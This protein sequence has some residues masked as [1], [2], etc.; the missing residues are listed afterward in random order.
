MDGDVVIRATDF[1]RTT[2][3]IDPATG[4]GLGDAVTGT[5]AGELPDSLAEIAVTEYCAPLIRLLTVHVPEI[6]VLLGAAKQF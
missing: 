5:L 4:S 6:L 1:L 2:L 3:V